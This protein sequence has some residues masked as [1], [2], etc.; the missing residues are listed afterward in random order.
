M[1]RFLATAL[2]AAFLSFLPDRA[3]AAPYFGPTLLGTVRDT[4]GT[5]LPF[6]QVI[7]AEAGRT[8]T[9]DVDG[10]FVLR[11]LPAGTYHITTLLIGYRPGHAVAIV[12][13]TGP[14]VT[15]DI[16]MVG[17]TLRLQA[18]NVTAASSSGEAAGAAQATAELSGKQL[19]RSLGAS[20]AQTLAAEPGM[21]MRYNGPAA[22]MPVIR[23][24]SGE[25][26][27]V[28]QDGARS[29][30]LASSAPDHGTSVDPLAAQRIEV[31]RGP[32]S[33][34]YGN[35]ALGGVVN[36][37][38]NDMPSAVPAR[39][40]GS[41]ASQVES[42]NP[43]GAV[44]V[45]VIHP[46]GST[47]AV[48]VR[49]GGRRTN[50]VRVGGGGVLDGTS[51]RN[52]NTVLGYGF[53]RDR[54]QGG[55][56]LKA[57][58]FNYGL[59]AEPGSD[60]SGIRIDGRRYQV[61]GRLSANTGWRA[62]RQLR[63]EGSVQ[64][65]AQQEIEPDGA[66]GTSLTLRTQT[67]GVTAPAHFGRMSGTIGA[68]LLLRQYAAEGEEALTPAANSANGGAFI[69]QELPLGHDGGE[70]PEGGAR[71]QVGARFDGYRITSQAG[72]PRFGAARTLSFNNFS[73]SLG[74][75]A[76]LAEHVTLSG[77][78]ARAFRAPSVEELFS[79]AVHA[80]TASYEMGSPDLA[81][82]RS[83][84]V[85]VVLRVSGTGLSGQLAGYVNRVENYIAPDVSRDTTIDGATMP[86]ARYGQRDA[87]LRG[88]EGQGEARLGERFVLGVMGDVT[89]GTFAGGAPLPF[90]P[91][92]RVGA[93]LRWDNR[94]F[95]A[96]GEVRHVLAQRRVTGGQDVPAQAYTL[97][98]LSASWTLPVGGR[99]HEVTLRAD[100]IGDVRYLDAT[101]RIKSYAPN[102]GRNVSLVYG[103]TF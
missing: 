102:P 67:A 29:G 5:P 4:S 81:V 51:N 53:V 60:A 85:D 26:I 33:L 65:F 36:V 39:V 35:S 58:D 47:S 95:N 24:L 98:N 22:T 25:R 2:A 46:L 76:P 14:D 13:A 84:G 31:V 80:A 6:V 8:T 43:G 50:P 52:L 66:V 10:R 75:S 3:S 48:N 90:M 71:L 101:S 44:S 34:L 17:S 68:Q 99:L 87:M 79:N 100:N 1:L 7:V 70:H 72:D 41:V 69:Y 20:L 88:V 77:S 86:L 54:V 89:R 11:G 64:D 32:A 61:A 103:V 45:G 92:A 9:T 56:T 40:T 93:S 28:L 83:L 16:V 62:V 74:L 91:A 63:F 94:S 18:V 97:L 12:A 37:I 19:Q 73:G 55:L 57:F 30:D 96:G 21:S 15:V 42:V 78:V 23:G 59:P 27:L 49:L 82:E 38:S